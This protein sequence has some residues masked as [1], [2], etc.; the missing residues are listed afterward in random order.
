VIVLPRG[1]EFPG[2]TRR[3]DHRHHIVYHPEEVV[4]L[5]CREHHA[6]ITML[7]GIHGRRVR[8]QLSN[9]H[10]W[11]LWYQWIAGKLKPRRTRKALEYIEEW[12]RKPDPSPS[13]AEPCLAEPVKEAPKKRKGSAKK[14]RST[15]VTKPRH[16]TAVTKKRR[17]G[18]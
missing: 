15:Y 7:N 13:V 18:K 8:H 9:S 11:W 5:L 16:R 3:G 2:C 4:K 6:E 10:R 14:K 12:D 17:S 1:C